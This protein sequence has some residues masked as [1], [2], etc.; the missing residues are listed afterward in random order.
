MAA[1]LKCFEI[2]IFQREEYQSTGQ[3]SLAIINLISVVI[4]LHKKVA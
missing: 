1:G 2:P 3:W 4:R